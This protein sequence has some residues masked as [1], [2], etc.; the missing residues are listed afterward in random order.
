MPTE[1]NAQDMSTTTFLQELWLN[2]QGPGYLNIWHRPGQI[3]HPFAIAGGFEAVEAK[4][5]ELTQQGHHVY[6]QVGLQAT[7][8]GPRSRGKEATTVAIPG[9]WHDTDIAG[10]GHKQPNLPKDLLAAQDL[11]FSLPLAPTMIVY[12]GGGFYP[13]WNFKRPWVF[14]DDADREKAKAL[15]V[16]LHAFTN[17]EGH[18]RGYTFDQTADLVR[19]LR[20]PGSMNV[21]DPKNPRPVQV[22]YY[23]PANRYTPDEIEQAFPNVSTTPAVKKVVSKHMPAAPSGQYPMADFDKVEASCAWVHHC[24]VDAASLP[25]P[26][27]YAAVSIACLCQD[28]HAQVHEISR[29]YPDYSVAETDDKI[30]KAENNAGPR[31]CANIRTACGGEQFCSGCSYWGKITSPI[32]LGATKALGMLSVLAEL[33]IPGAP[34]AAG[35]VIPSGYT[36]NYEKGTWCIDKVGKDGTSIPFRVCSVPVVI[37]SRSTDVNSGTEFVELAWFK[38]KKWKH[39]IASRRTIADAREI[40]ALTDFGLPVTSLT[41]KDLVKFL[42]DFEIANSDNIPLIHSSSHLGWQNDET[43]L[44]GEKLLVPSD[45]AT[46]EV[47]NFRAQDDGDAQIA[48]GFTTAGTLQKWTAMTNELYGYSKVL[49]TV[50]A[51]LAAPFIRI[52]GAENFIVDIAG[53]TSK[54]KT[55]TQVL[56][57]SAWG[58]PDQRK[59]NSVLHTWDGTDVWFERAAALLNGFPLILDDTK[60]ARSEEVIGKLVYR[61]ASGK[62]KARGTLTGTRETGTWQSIL[63]SSGEQSIIDYANHHGG[64]KARVLS[65]W[66]SPY[67]NGHQGQFVKHV[68]M[69]AKGNYDHAGP[70]VVQFIL[71]H[72]EDWPLWQAAYGEMALH[73]SDKAAGNTVLNRLSAI[74]A[75]FAVT[76]PLI[77]AA[78]PGLSPTRP[79][80]EIIEELWPDVMQGAEQADKAKDALKTLWEWAVANQAKFWGRHKIDSNGNPCEPNQGWAG[81]WGKPGEWDFLAVTRATLDVALRDFEVQAMIKTWM[82]HGWLRLPSGGKGQQ[83]SVRICGAPCSAYVIP[84]SIIAKVLEMDLAAFDNNIPNDGLVP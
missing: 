15:S 71:D 25:E 26:E 7:N 3:T 43:F 61:F 75:F 63:I 78:L 47:V 50:M 19:V 12:S 1:L 55:V 52:L 44:F 36:M 39:R 74:L 29:P 31:T 27:W 69:M 56:A 18:K 60:T 5:Q 24:V 76:I 57:A 53:E 4:V 9:F 41:S 58:N 77:H 28:G 49:T 32:Q 30:A 51:A 33:A 80:H 10:P 8:V 14:A 46:A 13:L 21:K 65:I 84:K 17:A 66:G 72:R 73:F 20:I 83:K 45:D 67:G 64:T 6:F 42:D 11:I 2:Y 23:E 68:E 38:D 40:M 16:R 59:P 48:R 22:I 37:V 62:G 82:G 79:I 70:M 81:R 54:G 35:T 34:M